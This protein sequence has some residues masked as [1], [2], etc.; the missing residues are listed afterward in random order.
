M[1]CL[2]SFEYASLPAHPCL[3]EVKE[4]EAEI[5]VK[6]RVCMVV[7]APTCTAAAVH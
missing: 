4:L 6:V 5:K 1:H 3:Q 7:R 2:A